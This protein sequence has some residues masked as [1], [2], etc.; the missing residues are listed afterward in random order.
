MKYNIGQ[1]LY[2]LLNKETKIC[3]I[4]VVEEITKK[5]LEGESTIYVVRFGKKSDTANLD[6][7]DGQV[8]DSIEV[9]RSTL[10]ER[11]I[12]TIDVVISNT[13]KRS[14]EWYQQQEIMKNSQHQNELDATSELIQ[15]LDEAIITLPDGTVA[16]MKSSPLGN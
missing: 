14:Q 16:K 6:D 15:E 4:Q 5:T 2:V 13:L 9:L 11:V 3:P 1:V 7:L 8:F 12:R 10:H